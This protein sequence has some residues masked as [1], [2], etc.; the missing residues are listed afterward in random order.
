MGCI[1]NNMQY[2]YISIKILISYYSYP[3]LMEYFQKIKA[4]CRVDGFVTAISGRR[5]YIP[6]INSENS[7]K[8]AKAERQ[9]VN[10]TIQGSAADVMKKAMIRVYDK[11]QAFNSKYHFES[12]YIGPSPYNFR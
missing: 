9:A 6:N 8:R 5:R 12:S 10:S 1:N 3:T 4:K 2:I 7:S 11:L